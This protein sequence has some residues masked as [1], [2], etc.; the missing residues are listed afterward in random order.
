MKKIKEKLDSL[1]SSLIN[2]L[3]KFSWCS[4]LISLAEE[5]LW[6]NNFIFKARISCLEIIAEKDKI[7]LEEPLYD[8]AE[9]R[10]LKAKWKRLETKAVKEQE[11][12]KRQ[13]MLDYQSMI[14]DDAS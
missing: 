3:D 14:D 7:W 12:Y 11:A 2:W 13:A 4:S 8:E 1:V 5:I 9:E 10:A 6:A